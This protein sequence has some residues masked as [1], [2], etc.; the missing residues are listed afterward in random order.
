MG[1]ES[2]PS[3]AVERHM[4]HSDDLEETLVQIFR[5]VLLR[6]D[7]RPSDDF[8]V[9]GGDSFLAVDLTL[10]IEERTGRCIP[11]LL[12]FEAS[13]AAA[14]AREIGAAAPD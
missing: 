6:D 14:L 10:A 13:T 8:F 11:L 3:N 2:L 7:V 4:P 5:D 9:L 12:V 1:S